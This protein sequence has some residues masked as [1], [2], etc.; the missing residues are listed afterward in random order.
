MTWLGFGATP[1]FRHSFAAF[2]PSLTLA[3]S[4]NLARAV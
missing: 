3:S 2:T 1:A 4:E